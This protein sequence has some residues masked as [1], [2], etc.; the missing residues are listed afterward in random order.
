METAARPRKGR[1]AGKA[2]GRRPEWREDCSEGE[3]TVGGREVTRSGGGRWWGGGRGEGREGGGVGRAEGE[4]GE[5]GE[6]SERRR[7]R[8]KGSGGRFACNFAIFALTEPVSLFEQPP[9]TPP[10]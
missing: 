8:G 4:Q 1:H 6:D 9:H 3:E 5:S 2:A 7:R 10:F